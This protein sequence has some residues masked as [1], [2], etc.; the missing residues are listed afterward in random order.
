[1]QGTMSN[2]TSEQASRDVL[3]LMRDRLHDVAIRYVSV[4][5][6]AS[7]DELRQ[8]FNDYCKAVGA[9]NDRHRGT[10][11]GWR[12]IVAGRV[13]ID[14]IHALSTTQLDRLESELKAIANEPESGGVEADVS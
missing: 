4:E 14:T 1:M 9:D 11:I 7:R 13:V 2:R 5:A 8:S 12:E 10:T 6:A 3:R